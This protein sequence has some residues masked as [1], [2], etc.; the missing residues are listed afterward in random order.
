M[1]PAG[2]G[3]RACGR[4]PLPRGRRRPA[5]GE[6]RPPVTR[7]FVIVPNPDGLHERLDDGRPH[8][9]EPTP[10]QVLG[11]SVLIRELPN[12]RVERA[13]LLPQDKQRLRVPDGGFDLRP[14][15]DDRFGF[16]KPGYVL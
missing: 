8:E 9:P 2:Y 14:I 15:A 16:E 6:L 13:E 12:V 11:E 4:E 1:G 5:P 10:F 7:P 3:A